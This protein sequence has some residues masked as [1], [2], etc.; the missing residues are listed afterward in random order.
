MQVMT[1]SKEEVL[2]K[3]TR[4]QSKCYVLDTLRRSGKSKVTKSTDH[5]NRCQ[6]TENTLYTRLMLTLHSKLKLDSCKSFNN[7]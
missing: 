4:F 3:Y 5:K 6:E 1:N 7:I 2:S